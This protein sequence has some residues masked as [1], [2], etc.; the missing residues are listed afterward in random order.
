MIARA[1][2]KNKLSYDLWGES[3]NTASRMESRGIVD[4]IQVAQPTY[5]HIRDKF[6]FENTGEIE[7]GGRNRNQEEK[8]HANLSIESQTGFG[9]NTNQL[10]RYPTFDIGKIRDICLVAS[11]EVGWLH[12][13]DLHLY[14]RSRIE[15]RLITAAC[16]ETFQGL[17]AGTR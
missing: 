9:A 13:Q 1:I 6:F 3:V 2:G 12:D 4:E 10:M 5:E 16:C 7:T 11:S 17:Y 15:E 14:Q 8:A